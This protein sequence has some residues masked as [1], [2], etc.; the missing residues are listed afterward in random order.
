[1]YIL[2]LQKRTT[3]HVM[4]VSRYE[5]QLLIEMATQ[6]KTYQ[7][8]QRE[9]K[10]VSRESKRNQK[11]IKRIKEKIKIKSKINIKNA[12]TPRRP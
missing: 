1:M 11:R 4:K 7:E 8:N 12:E 2:R 9:I 10:N 5:S 3:F 6:A